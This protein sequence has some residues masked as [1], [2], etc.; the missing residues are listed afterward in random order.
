MG[1]GVLEAVE[2]HELQIAA[3]PSIVDHGQ[4][5]NPDLQ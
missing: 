1:M 2:A 4:I 3:G 5:S